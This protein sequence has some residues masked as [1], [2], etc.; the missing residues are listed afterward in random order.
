MY[1]NVQK[2]YPEYYMKKFFI[3]FCIVNA[4]FFCVYSMR[5]AVPV[6]GEDSVGLFQACAAPRTPLEHRV[7]VCVPAQLSRM[8]DN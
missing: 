7:G 6:S 8:R 3:L 4:R 2:N 1:F 5:S